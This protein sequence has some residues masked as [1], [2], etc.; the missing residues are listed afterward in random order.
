MSAVSQAEWEGRRGYTAPEVWGPHFWQVNF[1]LSRR[2][3]RHGPAAAR[4]FWEHMARLAT[5]LPCRRCQRH[6]T[7]YVRRVP[8][9][10]LPPAEWLRQLYARVERRKL[11]KRLGPSLRRLVEAHLPDPTARFAQCSS[12]DLQAMLLYLLLSADGPAEAA[13]HPD[14]R[15]AL[16]AVVDLYANLSHPAAGLPA[17]AAIRDALVRGLALAEDDERLCL[18]GLYRSATAAGA[19]PQTLGGLNPA[20]RFRTRGGRRQLTGRGPA[21]ALPNSVR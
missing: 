20:N 8:L 18:W 5:L 2:C 6:L 14:R 13:R 9:R 17:A 19:G 11:K 16:Q 21:V 7:R 1:Q 15:A 10:S 3:G 12:D 4:V